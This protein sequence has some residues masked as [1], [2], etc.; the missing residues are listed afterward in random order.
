[1]RYFTLDQP[2]ILPAMLVV[3]LLPVIAIIGLHGTVSSG[4]TTICNLGSIFSCPA[5]ICTAI[6][7]AG[8][9]LVLFLTSYS[10][11][12][13]IHSFQAEPVFAFERPPR[14]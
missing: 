8:L 3:A 12:I 13:L 6:V 1:M 11:W 5:T 7:A 14:Q 2:T 4:S 9:I 10:V